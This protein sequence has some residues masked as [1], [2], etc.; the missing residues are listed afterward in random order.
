MLFILKM[1][2]CYVI[3]GQGGEEEKERRAFMPA[4]PPP[5]KSVRLI[6]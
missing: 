6:K 2:D 5:P 1:S 3:S 4:T